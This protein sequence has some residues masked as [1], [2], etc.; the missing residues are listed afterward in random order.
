MSGQLK[1][2]ILTAEMVPFA[3][4]GGLADVA[5]ALPKALATLGHDVRVALPRYGRID[6]ARFGLTVEV[7][8]FPVTIDSGTE[9]VSIER[10]AIRAGDREIPV[11]FVANERLFNR[12]GVYGYPDDGER[13][14]LFCR[15]ALEMLKRI[16]WQPD[17]IHCNDW[18]T[19]LVPNW[20]KTIYRDD[21]FFAKTAT[22]YTIHNLQYQGVFGRRILEVAGIEAYGFL[23]HP[24]MGELAKVV[25]FMARGI[26]FADIVTTVSERY[27]QEI[28][29]PEYGEKLDPL[30]RDRRDRLFGVL[31]GIDYDDA[32]PATDQ[33][34]AR[35]F[36]AEHL[37]ARAENK[38]ALQ[39]EAGLT[40]DPNAPLLGLVSRMVDQKGFDLL[41]GIFDWLMRSL[42]VQ[43]VLLG[44]GDQHYHTLFTRFQRTYPGQAA[45][46]L[47]FNTPFAQRIY[48]GSDMFLMPSRFEP[49][50][51]GQL[52]AL[53][54]GSI[55]VVRRTGGL[56]DTV[57]DFDPLT[58]EGNGFVFERY[59]Q[60]D[61]YTAIVRAVEHYRNPRT[62]Q[63]L[64]RR[65][66]GADYSW[67]VSARKYADLYARAIEFRTS[68][69]A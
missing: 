29:T 14:V 21:P 20:L 43:F 3:K 22:V 26:Y 13:F 68:E 39:R 9:S 55:P 40:V 18:H 41:S 46:N 8:P 45:A 23:Y 66:M 2:L 27:A 63:M 59:D 53:R 31:N 50:G 36:D 6:G 25:D 1:I 44:A 38:A 65:G 16:D 24:Q 28:L 48:A 57:T 61:L 4:T 54:Y 37:D 62:W 47:T 64:Q 15:A 42:R 17:V 56:A 5:G 33:H 12:E 30:L 49:C 60:V 7:D 52:M 11:Y 35:Q 32:N 69:R 10:S 58:E 67:G 51:L 19:G 34:I